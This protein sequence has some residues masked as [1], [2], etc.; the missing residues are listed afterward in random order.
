MQTVLEMKKNDVIPDEL[1]LNDVTDFQGISNF[2]LV[3]VLQELLRCIS[4]SL[5]YQER[6]CKNLN[7]FPRY[8]ISNRAGP[9]PHWQH[10]KRILSLLNFTNAVGFFA[11]ILKR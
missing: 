4:P 5:Y 2:T 7:V 1:R 10:L 8:S 11:T 9:I 3:S 6:A